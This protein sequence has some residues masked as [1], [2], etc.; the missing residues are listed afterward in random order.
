MTDEAQEPDTTEL[1]L[2]AQQAREQLMT[3]LARLDQRAKHMVHQATD[4]SLASGLCAAAAV[5]FWLSVSFI[6][7]PRAQLQLRAQNTLAPERVR[8]RSVMSI[9]LRTVVVAAGLVATGLLVQAAQRRTRN[10]SASVVAPGR[11]SSWAQIGQV[12]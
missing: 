8:P 2:R 11:R 9:A 10:L 12:S 4:A 5:T 1:E 6:R 7:R 3:S